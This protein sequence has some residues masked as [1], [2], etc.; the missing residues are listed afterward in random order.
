[1]KYRLLALVSAAALCF[2]GCYQR[3]DPVARGAAVGGVAGSA[4]GAGTGALIGAAIAHGDIGASALLG[5]GIGLPVGMVL[6]AMYVKMH[7]DDTIER[8]EKRIVENRQ[9]ILR[10][11]QEIEELRH[12]LHSDSADVHVDEELREY[13]Y[14][15]PSLGNYY[16]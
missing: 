11:H 16:R 1:M 9:Q 5:A 10:R 15:G 3:V 14:Q 6:G 4:V 13:M 8:N 12:R 2:C 7:Q